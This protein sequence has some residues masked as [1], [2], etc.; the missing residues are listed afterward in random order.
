MARGPFTEMSDGQFID[1]LKRKYNG[2]N[3]AELKRADSKV[4]NQIMMR[5]L[6]VSLNNKGIVVRSRRPSGALKYA[7][8][9]DLKNLVKK[10]YNGLTLTGLED[11]D[12]S[13]TIELRNRGILE[14]LVENKV[15]VRKS[16]PKG[17]YSRAD[18]D[19]LIQLAAGYRGKTISDVENGGGNGLIDELRKRKLIGRAESEAG[20]IR[21]VVKNRFKGMSNKRFA[22]YI[23]ENHN[24]DT[25]TNIAQ[26]D[27]AVYREIKSRELDE[28]LIKK[29]V[30]VRKKTAKGKFSN[31]ADEELLDYFRENYS[32]RT[33]SYCQKHGSRPYF[34]LSKRGLVDQLV[35]EG[36]LVTK[37]VGYT[38]MSN[39][40]FIEYVREN[41]SGI[42]LP[43]LIDIR[44]QGI[45]NE[46]N[47][48]GLLEKLLEE[49]TL[50]KVDRSK[51]GS[52]KDQEFIELIK[53]NYSGLRITELIKK[54]S[55]AVKEL[56]KRDLVE[57]VVNMGI[58]MKR[59]YKNKALDPAYLIEQDP[60]AR[61]IASLVGLTDNVGDIANILVQFWPHR[62][63]SAAEL[64][65]SLPKA[66]AR[67]GHH[68]QPF[69]L[70][71]T[72][73]FYQRLGSVPRRVYAALDDL[74][75]GIFVDQ[76]QV[77]FN[78][79]PEKTIIDIKKFT[80]GE[81]KISSL[82]N[83]VLGY[84]KQVYEFDVPGHGK[85]GNRR[86]SA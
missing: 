26:G 37:R 64:A 41:C 86:R 77:P 80:H 32:G 40:S 5:D 39:K 31:M 18:D 69:T 1:F 6:Q 59:G 16:K 7:S 43:E 54:D 76:Y 35:D 49:G 53:N 10:K 62:F 58:L 8:D 52:L 51:Y 23:E 81:E 46:A 19:K 38:T 27:K 34:L 71:E 63:P 24:G 28:S 68:L 55:V 3:L 50:V 48:R 47:K 22:E 70:G 82:A 13:L 30:L 2:M 83:R 14:E 85:I 33:P 78:E 72:R 11:A 12:G 4:Y 84:Y 42:S 67:I 44:A 15:L 66:I 57:Q 65:K 25:L 36:V 21:R 17:L 60:T 79:N 75:Y 9:I 74:L 73:G 56:R 20:L 61:T 29:G 45:W